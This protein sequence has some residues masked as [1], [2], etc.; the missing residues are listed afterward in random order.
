MLDYC[1][2]SHVMSC[3]VVLGYSLRNGGIETF[4]KRDTDSEN[5]N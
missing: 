4:G 2:S 5:E 3:Y 1:M